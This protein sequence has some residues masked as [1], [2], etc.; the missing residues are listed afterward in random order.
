MEPL[1]K[2]RETDYWNV[3]VEK[4]P[5]PA[6]KPAPAARVGRRLRSADIIYEVPPNCYWNA[7]KDEEPANIIKEWSSALP[8]ISDPVSSIQDFN[9]V[10]RDDGYWSDESQVW[11]RF[12][13]LEEGASSVDIDALN[14]EL[15]NEDCEG[16]CAES[17]PNHMS[18]QDDQVDDDFL[19]EFSLSDL[20]ETIMN[21]LSAEQQRANENED[22]NEQTADSDA[23]TDV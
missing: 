11:E 22:Q 2:V 16:G 23:S 12:L 15:A 5:F 3:F 21:F 1:F 10:K 4:K 8:S 20:T 17:F 9:Y 18:T 14:K 13:A 19:D 7:L 6:I